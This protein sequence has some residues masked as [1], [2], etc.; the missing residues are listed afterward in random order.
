MRTTFK[1]TYALSLL[2]GA[3]IFCTTANVSAM[4]QDNPQEHH[5][6]LRRLAPGAL[7]RPDLDKTLEFHKAV[8]AGDLAKAETL[9]RHGVIDR[10]LMQDTVLT[11]AVR[12]NKPALMAK[13]MNWGADINGPTSDTNPL[14]AAHNSQGAFETLVRLGANVNHRHAQGGSILEAETRE[15]HWDNV[16]RLIYAG[17]DVNA[18]GQVGACTALTMAAYAADVQGVQILV[19]HAT[20]KNKENAM[21]IVQ[22]RLEELQERFSSIENPSQDYLDHRNQEIGKFYDILNLLG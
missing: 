13:L 9:L 12:N 22:K 21:D 19:H 17:A 18:A 1:K 10:P 16:R 7:L 20:P 8:K 3:A 5:P 6:I 4:D 2:M 15:R 11:W 14:R